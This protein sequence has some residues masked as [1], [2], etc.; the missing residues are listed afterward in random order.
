MEVI[1]YFWRWFV[2]RRSD[3]SES[4]A[5]PNNNKSVCACSTA[6]DNAD[7]KNKC[8]CMCG[9]VI[10]MFVCVRLP[11]S[12]ADT[13]ESSLLNVSQQNGSIVACFTS[14]TKTQMNFP[15][16]K[17]HRGRNSWGKEMKCQQLNSFAC[18]SSHFSY[19]HIHRR[20][21][22]VQILSC[23]CLFFVCADTPYRVHTRID[24]LM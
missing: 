5:S 16:T 3:K 9:Q 11:Q 8:L 24:E 1:D 7:M 21:E 15:T 23:F 12:V 2:H 22:P 18:S 20:Q 17:T 13:E 6:L 4:L 19:H 14:L 10:T